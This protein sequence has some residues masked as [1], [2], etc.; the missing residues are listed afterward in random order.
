WA[1]QKIGLIDPLTLL[2]PLSPRAI[3]VSFPR[4][5]T[6]AFSAAGLASSICSVALLTGNDENARSGRTFGYLLG[7]AKHWAIR[8]GGHRGDEFGEHLRNLPHPVVIKPVRP[9]PGQ[10]HLLIRAGCEKQGRHPMTVERG[11]IECQALHRQ[12]TEF[13]RLARTEL[14][15][16]VAKEPRRLGP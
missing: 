7:V 4:P 6:I 5:E 11:L 2:F 12:L 10:V 1:E 3:H 9:V 13:E 15:E 8:M 16:Q 14:V